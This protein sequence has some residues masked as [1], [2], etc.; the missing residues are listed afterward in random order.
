MK[1]AV[2]ALALLVGAPAGQAQSTL[3]DP[4]DH[5]LDTYV[6]DGRVYYHALQKARGPL[7]RYLASLDVPAAEVAGWPKAS[8]EAFWID[9]YNAIVLQTVIDHYPIHGT[10]PAYPSSSIRQVAG[11]FDGIAHRVAGRS[12]TLDQIETTVLAGFGDARLFLA[13]GRGALG[14][15]RL[16]SEA[17]RGATLDQQLDAVVK[18]CAGHL[19]C[20]DVEVEQNTLAVTPVVSW[21]ADQ[22]VRSFGA[23]DGRWADRS[24]V[25]RAVVSMVYPY[26]F[27]NE[28]AF[29]ARDTFQM[30]YQTFDW[31]LNDL[32]VGSPPVEAPTP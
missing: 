7:D 30:T 19:A 6:R 1:L 28:R 13:L 27:P 5:L 22:F 11:A 23:T 12:L 14:S 17:Y 21:R 4:L 32:G 24:P 26:L 2:T 3:H 29:L 25:E 10:S 15:S 31:R 16:R 9:A 20:V 8:Q 18:E